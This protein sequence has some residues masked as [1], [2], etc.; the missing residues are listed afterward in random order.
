MVLQ[1]FHT[2]RH[3]RH[4]LVGNVC[5]KSC[6]ILVG[7]MKSRYSPIIFHT[8]V[9]GAANSVCKCYDSIHNVV[10]RQFLEIAFEFNF[11]CL[12]F[13]IADFILLLTS[14]ITRYHTRAILSTYFSHACNICNNFVQTLAPYHYNPNYKMNPPALQTGGFVYLDTL[15]SENLISSDF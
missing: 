15:K 6:I 12:I 13:G 10:I 8:E 5:G 2:N 7:F 1:Q 4:R 3:R 14:F 9:N 11:Q